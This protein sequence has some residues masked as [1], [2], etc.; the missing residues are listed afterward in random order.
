MITMVKTVFFK[1]STLTPIEFVMQFSNYKRCCW[2]AS[3][4]FNKAWSF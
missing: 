2:E 4:G 3:E 1:F